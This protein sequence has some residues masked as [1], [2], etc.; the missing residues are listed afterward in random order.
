V[1]TPEGICRQRDE[2]GRSDDEREKAKRHSGAMMLA[3]SGGARE[4]IVSG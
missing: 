2:D 3:I 4:S 1:T